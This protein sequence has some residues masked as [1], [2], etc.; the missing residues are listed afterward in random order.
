MALFCSWD[1]FRALDGLKFPATKEEILAYASDRDAQESS[2]VALN[3]LQENLIYKDLGAVCEN[4]KVI[5][6]LEIY[7]ILQEFEF[8]AKK[9]KILAFAKGKDASGLAITILE[10]LPEGGT[11]KSVDE[12]CS[13]V[14]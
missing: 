4:V 5:C 1:I 6:S 8:P 2:I 9:D 10:R 3:Q 13:S 14:L 11:F 7:R 12:V